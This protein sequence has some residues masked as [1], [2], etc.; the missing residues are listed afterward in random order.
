MIDSTAT[1]LGNLYVVNS[2]VANCGNI[3]NAKIHLKGN[4]LGF[5]GKLENFGTITSDSII[6]D[7]I[8]DIHNYNI[9]DANYTYIGLD[10]N[11]DNWVIHRTDYLEMYKSWYYFNIGHLF[12]NR[13]LNVI[14]SRIR[15]EYMIRCKNQFILDSLSRLF[16]G[17][18]IYVD[19]LFI[20]KGSITSTSLTSPKFSKIIIVGQSINSGVV[21]N[22]DI[23]DL[24]S[25]Y[26]GG[27]D[28]NSGT[29]NNITLCQTPISCPDYTTIGIEEKSFENSTIYAFPNPS[30]SHIS[31]KGIENH[32]E[33]ILSFKNI[34]GE[35]KLTTYN[36][37]NIDISS[38]SS[39]AYFIEIVKKDRTIKTLKFIKS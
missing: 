32:E 13:K 2:R 20:N 9:I 5:N 39:G 21:Y 34:I 25:L 8:G 17:C 19:S 37:Q 30:N 14:D 12:V 38:L 33:Y 11:I 16:N 15:N 36:I 4:W 31:I 1:L 6:V 22:M 27:F 7:T 26:A 3:T 29:L 23:C 24:S 10:G 18:T 35:I 28:V